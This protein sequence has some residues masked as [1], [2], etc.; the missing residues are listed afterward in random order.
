MPPR[1]FVDLDDIDIGHE[2]ISREE[3]R[4][5]VPQRFEMEQIEAIHHFDREARVAVGSRA[6]R[7]DEWWVRGH[8]PGRPIFPGVLIVEAAAQLCT[9][10]FK[11]VTEDERF[12]GF[13]GIDGVRFRGPVEPGDHLI[14]IAKIQQIRTRKSVLEC[15]GVVD[16]RMVFEGIITGMAV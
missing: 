6:V 5:I 16:G 2:L 9:W 8:V 15:Q 7:A 4:E 3:I 1:L 10:L 11:K 12:L 14:L 13:A